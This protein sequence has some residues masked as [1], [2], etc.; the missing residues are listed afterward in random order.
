MDKP[1]AA[2]PPVRAFPLARYRFEFCVTRAVRLPDYAGS[3][4]RGVFG[5]A[6]RQLACMTRQPQCDGCPLSANCPYL[7]VFAPHSDG[8]HAL[9]TFSRIPAPYIIEPP[10]WGARTLPEGSLLDF[11]MTLVGGALKELP[12]IVLAWQR[13]LARGIGA[14]DGTA[15]LLRVLHSPLPAG[16]PEQAI[17]RPGAGAIDAHTQT[18]DAGAQDERPV[19][20]I[21]LCFTTPLRLQQNGHALSPE[22]LTARALLMALIRRASLLSEFHAGAPLLTDFSALAARSAEIG[23]RRHLLWRDWTRYSSRQRQKMR[24]GG[25]LGDWTLAGELA[26]FIPFLRLGE[27]LHVGKEATFGMG[28]YTL[29]KR[30]G[31]DISRNVRKNCETPAQAHEKTAFIPPISTK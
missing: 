27:W 11:H 29:R 23:D 6:L 31:I 2:R 15:D 7:A 12:L 5:R 24:L 21:T 28:G 3:M 14:G 30:P 10:A 22:R 20:Q 9:Q 8:P 13:A 25:V 26:P 17:Y 4:L 18:V 16:A 1:I 19:T